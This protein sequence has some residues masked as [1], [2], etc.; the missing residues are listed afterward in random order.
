MTGRL[1]GSG[2]TGVGP[3]GEAESLPHPAANNRRAGG[4]RKEQRLGSFQERP[5]KGVNRFNP[6]ALR[7]AV[8]SSR[9][10]A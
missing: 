10:A 9:Y 3:T 2:P 5:F 8:R 6:D 4:S 1:D 7:S